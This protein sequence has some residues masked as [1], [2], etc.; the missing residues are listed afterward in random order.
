[1]KIELLEL[2]LMQLQSRL[3]LLNVVK[4]QFTEDISSL[5]LEL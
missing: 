1:M 4:K 2:H 3:K 5:F